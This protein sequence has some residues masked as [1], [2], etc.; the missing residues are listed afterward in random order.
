MSGIRRCLS[1][2]GMLVLTLIALAGCSG[3][4]ARR[5]AGAGSK[6]VVA[7]VAGMPISEQALAHRVAIVAV[8]DHVSVPHAPR[9]PRYEKLQSQALG[10]LISARWQIAEAAAEGTPVNEGAAR[11]QLTQIESRLFPRK[12]LLQA[13]FRTS[14]KTVA[15]LLLETEANDA[16]TRIHEHI[17]A[18]VPKLTAA[19]IASYYKGHRSH[20]RIPERR[21]LKILRTGTATEA[22]RAKRELNAGAS[23]AHLA[24]KSHI[25]QPIFTRAGLALGVVNNFYKE[26]PLND[27]IFAAEP[28]VL[29]GPVRIY[30][31]YYIFEVKRIR[32]PR[33]EGLAEAGNEIRRQLPAEILQRNELHFIASWRARWRA[34]TSCAP[35]YVMA[36]CS[37]YKGSLSED[38][39]ALD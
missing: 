28:N 27:A 18:S 13:Y 16:S 1:A 32:P 30:L 36:K 14:R 15:D 39:S 21:D 26:K 23:F 19:K 12:A 8:E 20:Y 9:G 22:I 2:L 38:P 31:G 10:Y 7:T 5:N 6:V 25:A 33:Q 35:D 34:R 24:G 37:Q 3:G 4:T 11:M 29:K 17:A